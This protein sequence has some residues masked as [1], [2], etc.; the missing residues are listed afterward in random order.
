MATPTIIFVPGFWEG[1][2]IFD[3]VASTLNAQGY[4]TA[5]A[6]IA[7]TGH[8]SPGNPTILDDI[9]QIRRVIEPHVLAGQ[10]VV[11]VCHSSGG[12]MGSAAIKDLDYKTRRARGEKGGVVKLVFLTAGILPQGDIFPDILPFHDIQVRLMA[13]GRKSA[14]QGP[15]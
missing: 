3:T 10:E 1:P 6:P 11:L 2:T 12:C 4:D 8:A 7:S 13:S 14:S 15:A 5:Y 9:Q